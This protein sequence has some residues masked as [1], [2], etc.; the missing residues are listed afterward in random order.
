MIKRVLVLLAEGFEDIEA[1]APVDILTRVGVE[2]TIAALKDGPVKAAYGTTIV[3]HTV[4]NK[5]DDLYDGLVLPG[6][7]ENAKSL[8][9][10]PKVVELVKEHNHAGKMIAAICASP[11][12]VL[13]DKTKI[14]NGK[15]ATG[16]PDFSERLVSAGAEVTDRLVTV[17]GNIITGMGPGAAMLFAL[18]LAEYLTGK[19]TVDELVERWRIRDIIS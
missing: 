13:A 9:E 1:I 17:D 2:V 7:M 18:K 11:A 6:G 16:H 8:A 10:H 12:C 4:V 3:P 14:L 15:K 5:I 19:E